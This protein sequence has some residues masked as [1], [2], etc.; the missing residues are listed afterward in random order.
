[1]CFAEPAF[2]TEVDWLLCDAVTQLSAPDGESTYLRLSTRPIDQ[3][4]FSAARDRIGPDELR[5][6]LLFH[7][8]A[9]EERYEASFIETSTTLETAMGQDIR[10]NLNPIRLNPTAVDCSKS[11]ECGLRGKV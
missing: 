1:M 2:A 8:V 10:V 4:A 3:T 5:R 6:L 11:T 7:V 9:G